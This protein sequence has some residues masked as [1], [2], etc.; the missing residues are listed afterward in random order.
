MAFTLIQ[1]GFTLEFG[2]DPKVKEEANL[3]SGS[4]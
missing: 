3:K 2:F 4:Y 1:V